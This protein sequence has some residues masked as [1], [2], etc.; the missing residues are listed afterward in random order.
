MRSWGDEERKTCRES[1]FDC[2]IISYK[3]I[4]SLRQKAQAETISTGVMEYSGW[5]GR[6]SDPELAHV[7]MRTYNGVTWNI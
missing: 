6:L 1:R 4:Q 3:Y 2:S 7:K 5:I